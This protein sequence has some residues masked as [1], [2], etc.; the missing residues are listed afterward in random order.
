MKISTKDLHIDNLK[1]THWVGI[2]EDSQD[3]LFE[4][5][6]RIRIL[7]KFDGRIDPSNNESEFIIPTDN[8]PWARPGNKF[9]GGS[10]TGSGTFDVPKLNSIVKV[11]FDNGDIYSP[12]YHY[13]LYHSDDVQTEIGNSYDNAHVLLYDTAFE[14]DED[15]NN[16]REGEHIK[17][18]F[19]EEKGLMFDYGTAEGST[20]INI[21]P[22]NSVEVINANGD[23]IVM[24]NDGNITF[25]HSAK[26]TINSTDNTEINCKDSIVNCDNS[27]INSDDNTEINCV[28]ASVNATGETHINS[29]RIKLGESAAESVI[30]GDTFKS[31]FDSHIHP[32]GVGPSGPPTPPAITDSYL[33]KKNTTD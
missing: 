29:P 32:T 1:N 8:L 16:N 9:T 5:R 6:C 19:T 2:V 14:L 3:P 30:K 24:L 20:T 12:V 26:F 21:K 15:G 27:I 22:D 7:G 4:G 28:N 25:T 10:N 11:T 18:F 13:N 33:S 17:A 23:S 31:I